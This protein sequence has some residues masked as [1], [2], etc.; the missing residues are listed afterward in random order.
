MTAEEALELLR[1]NVLA[2]LDGVPDAVPPD[3]VVAEST[4]ADLGL[5]S[6][7]RL[8]VLVGSLDDAGLSPSV[9]VL[10]GAHT[11]A[12]LAEVLATATRAW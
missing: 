7:E 1:A 11:L 12:E 5:S 6:L 8:D 9:D 10:D 3:Q 2:V 4:L